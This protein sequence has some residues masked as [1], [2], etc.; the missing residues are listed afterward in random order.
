MSAAQETTIHMP[1]AWNEEDVPGDSTSILQ[2]SPANFAE[3]EFAHSARTGS[4]ND[5]PVFHPGEGVMP[6]IHSLSAEFGRLFSRFVRSP[7]HSLGLNC[8]EL[9]V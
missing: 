5:G 2:L 9:N 6:S 4:G 1:K 3:P 7:M 8:L